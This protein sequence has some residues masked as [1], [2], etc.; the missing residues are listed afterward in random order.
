LPDSPALLRS[1]AASARGRHLN[2]PSPQRPA[3]PRRALGAAGERTTALYLEQRGYRIIDRNVRLKAGEIDI[4]ADHDGCLVLV[5]VRVRRSASAGTALE[6]VG[7]RKQERLRRLSLE[8]AAGLG[9]PPRSVRIDVVAISIGRRGQV[10][11]IALIQ[12]AVEDV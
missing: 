11:E 1:V 3:D 10:M 8:F 2:S 4:V 12:N 6:S 5:E 9:G 7:P